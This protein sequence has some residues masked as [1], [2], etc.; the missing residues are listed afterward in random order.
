MLL[1]KLLAL[2]ISQLLAFQALT[3]GSP[4]RPLLV[5][6]WRG[7]DDALTEKLADAIEDELRRS[8]EF[9]LSTGKKP[10]T[11]IIKIP[12]N[13]DWKQVATRTKVLYVVQFSSDDRNLGAHSG[14]CWA[15]APTECAVR[16]V[17]NAKAAA[18]KIRAGDKD[19]KR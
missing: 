13:V 8:P 7:G 3:H 19:E 11:L 14:A 9:A 15:D 1:T 18:R 2:T 17:S 4:R 12:T 6:V 16:V 10:G 5:E